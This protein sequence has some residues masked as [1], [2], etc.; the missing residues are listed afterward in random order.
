MNKFLRILNKYKNKVLSA[1][2]A[3]LYFKEEITDT[4]RYRIDECKICPKN[5]DNRPNQTLR[6]K[7]WIMLN[8]LFNR[9]YGIKVTNNSVCSMCGCGTM[10][11]SREDDKES[12]KLG[13]WKY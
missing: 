6:E 3:R 2:Y 5:T 4:V 13:V 1:H 11:L 12:C 10:L 8:K 7:V 9:L